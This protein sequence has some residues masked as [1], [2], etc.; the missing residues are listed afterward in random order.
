MRW[1]ARESRFWVFWMRKTMS[2]VVSVVTVFAMSCQES[3]KLKI[4]PVISHARIEITTMMKT[5][6]E[7]DRSAVR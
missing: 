2:V 1:I 4:G 3:E 6:G 5:Q 7:P